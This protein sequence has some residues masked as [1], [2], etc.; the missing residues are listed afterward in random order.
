MTLLQYLLRTALWQETL[1]FGKGSPDWY[2][3]ISD[4]QKQT[5]LELTAPTIFNLKGE[6]RPPE[7][8]FWQ[9]TCDYLHNQKTYKTH[10]LFIAQICQKM[11]EAGCHPILLKGIAVARYYPSPQDRK[12]GDI[13]I[14]VPIEEFPQALEV[15]KRF[16]TKEQIDA[17]EEYNEHYQIFIGEIEIELHRIANGQSGREGY[18]AL[19][20]LSDEW[21]RP[22]KCRAIEI[23]GTMV[24]VPH[25]QF[26]AIFLVAHLWHHFAEINGVGLRQLC[27]LA[28]MLQSCHQD[29]DECLL[30]RHLRDCHLYRVWQAVGW[31]MVSWLGLSQEMCPC[32]GEKSEKKGRWLLGY[33]LKEGNFGAGG[34]NFKR[35]VKEKHPIL[36][37]FYSYCYYGKRQMLVDSLSSS[38]YRA[39]GKHIKWIFQHICSQRCST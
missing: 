3:L 34:L 26:E 39:I 29:M 30:E 22:E 17:A 2:S 15:L 21:L 33:I 8:L 25:P 12:C 24:L 28:M 37:K 20:Q 27:D 19:R 9:L 32:Y 1:S 14:Y 31:V 11:Q 5:V 6:R 38:E 16:A 4:L 13:D 7:N 36:H 23:E 35:T 10:C 18:A